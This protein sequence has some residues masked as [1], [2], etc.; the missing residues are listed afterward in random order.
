MFGNKSLPSRIYSYGAKPPIQGGEIVDQQ[1]RLASKYRNAIV[2]A[3]LGRRR[4]VDEALRRLS[5]E[6]SSIEG[7]IKETEEEIEIARAGIRKEN[8]RSRS[9]DANPETVGTIR[10]AKSKLKELRTRRKVLRTALFASEEW[11]KDNDEIRLWYNVERK[12][13]RSESALY[14]GTYLH[15]E[16]A[17]SNCSSGAPPRFAHWDGGGHLAVQIQHG[18]PAGGVF[19]CSDNRIRIEPVDDS[20]WLPG[21]RR[22]RRT[23]AWFR[24]GSDDKGGPVWAVVPFVLHRPIPVDASIKW[25]HLIRRRIG[26]HCEWRIQFV[27]SRAA[28]WRR[29]DQAESG[30]VGIDVGWRIRPGGDLRVAYWHDHDG[31]SGELCLPAGWLEQMQKTRDIQSIRDMRFNA[32]LAAIVRRLAVLA[33]P[34]WLREATQNLASWRSAG[35]LAAVAI[36][37]RTSRFNGDEET[38]AELESWRK[39]DKHLLEYGANLRDQLQR[40][41][42][43]LYRVFA[44]KLRR[45]YRTAV[46]EDLDLRNFHKLPKPEEE[47]A[48]P[49]LREHVRDACL[50]TLI[51][52]VKESMSETVEAPAKNTTRLHQCGSLEDWDRKELEHICTNCG[53]RYDQDLCAAVNLLR[54]DASVEVAAGI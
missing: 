16:Q 11:T 28:G 9:R 21:G 42:E 6:L 48:D 19:A 23:K 4:R 44:A 50:S 47:A 53:E 25:V 18:A 45:T 40:S 22:L 33:V 49:A 54:Y 1:M 29:S 8:Q 24:V 7:L 37:W 31:Q 10:G 32:A 43:D 12:R 38:F 52:C 26:T 35:R 17:M 34:D 51:K 39:R 41:R 27:L 36:R 3:E 30:R 20:A 15:V 2:E 14:W 5:P 46:I 13:I